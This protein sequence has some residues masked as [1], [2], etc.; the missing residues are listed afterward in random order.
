MAQY[1]SGCIHIPSKVKP[2]TYKD[3][4]SNKV[5]IYLQLSTIETKEQES[6]QEGSL[7]T[8]RC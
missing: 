8:A 5:Y 3:K 4:S 1:N 2:D 7:K 6:E